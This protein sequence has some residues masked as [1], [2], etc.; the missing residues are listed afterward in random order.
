MS[1]VQMCIESILIFLSHTL[2][3]FYS[4]VL[5]DAY[6]IKITDNSEQI[7]MS[8]GMSRLEKYL[9]DKFPFGCHSENGRDLLFNMHD[10][11]CYFWNSINS[12]FLLRFLLAFPVH[13]NSCCKWSYYNR[14]MFCD[15]DCDMLTKVCVMYPMVDERILE[16]KNWFFLISLQR[17]INKML[18]CAW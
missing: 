3:Y 17:I 15:A 11:N 10:L 12:S 8:I 2:C 14:W 9:N 1:I 7:C 5:F 18:S 16:E 4:R 13:N 6:R